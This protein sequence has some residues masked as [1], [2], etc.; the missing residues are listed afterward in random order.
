MNNVR[1]II[2]DLDGTLFDL[3]DI[4]GAARGRVADLLHQNGFFAS[5]SYALRRINELEQQHGPYYSS[6]PYYF[7]FYDIAKALSR[8]KPEAFT[9]F[10]KGRGTARA[11]DVDPIERF[12]RELESVYNREEVEDLRLFPDARQA[13]DELQ[14]AGYHLV[15]VTLGT[16]AVRQRN[17][18][19]R[20]GIA[21]SFHRIINEGPPSH[22][23]WFSE[24]LHELELKPEE[25]VCVGDRT[26][27]EIRAGNRLGCHTVWLRRG[28]YAAEEP[29]AGDRPEV[30]IR[31]LSQ[32]PTIL[33][34]ARRQKDRSRLRVAV[35]GGGTGLPTVLKGMLAY[36]EAPTAIVAV[37]DNGASSGRI[38]WNL[39]VQ[40]P[41]DIRNALTA[42]A[43]PNT[44]TPGLYQVFQH[45]FPNSEREAGIFKNDHIGNFLVA[46]LT[47]QAGDFCSAIQMAARMLNVRG[48][49]L[50]AT[51]QNVDIC[52]EL[53]NGEHRF[54]EWMVRK[55]D[56]SPI[57]ELYLV[58]NSDIL[59]ELGRKRGAVTQ[60]ED[61]ET[62]QVEIH[63]VPG[64]TFK[65]ERNR[66]EAVPEGV[67]AIAEAD[68]VVIGPGSLFTSVITNLLVPRIQETLLG[69]STGLTIYVS[70]ILTQPGQTDGYAASHHLQAILSHFP[71]A[72][73]SDLFNHALIQDPAVFDTP[74]GRDWKPLLKRYRTHGKERVRC[75]QKD[76]DALVP[77]TLADMVEEYG[78]DAMHRGEADFISHDP[79]RVADAICRVYCGMEIP[80]YGGNN[81]GTGEHR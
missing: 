24:L 16:N 69:R 23:Y 70:N 36:T 38:R 2:F 17:K 75:D 28:R 39:G 42:L 60:T 8:T 80:N 56:K 68:I 81:D 50:P 41:G 48:T 67:D 78:Q 22:D 77:W 29:A 5:R 79:H 43:D 54:T 49:V 63:A 76:L 51:S 25:V 13:L 64:K 52:A 35:I 61:P 26:H 12:V 33:Q 40:P 14:L 9:R 21:S 44:V 20:L 18:I 59:E 19:E 71:G 11:S 4:V 37:T 74:N 30:E 53:E 55:P 66:A 72:R 46:A 7:A 27:D 34:M 1:A 45:R 3:S 62:G 31:Y 6:S 10:L 47:Q 58:Q 65:P 15:L 57:R 32:L 73:P